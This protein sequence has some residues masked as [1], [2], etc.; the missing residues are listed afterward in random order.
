MNPEKLVRDLK[1]K[2]LPITALPLYDAMFY[3]VYVWRAIDKR[4]LLTA[5]SQLHELHEITRKY[6]RR[7]LK[8]GL[9]QHK[10]ILACSHSRLRSSAD[11]PDKRNRERENM[12]IVCG[13]VFASR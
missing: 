3:I 13:G 10:K 5:K 7:K 9:S 2:S 4:R 6:Q 12:L 8:A 1:I 11:K